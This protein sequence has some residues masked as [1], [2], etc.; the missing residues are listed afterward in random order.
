MMRQRRYSYRL[1]SCRPTQ[2]HIDFSRLATPIWGGST[3]RERSSGGC[4]PLPPSWCPV[5]PL[6]ETQSSASYSYRACGLP[7]ARLD[8]PDPPPRCNSRRGN[9]RLAA[10][11]LYLEPGRYGRRSLVAIGPSGDATSPEVI[12]SPNPTTT[13]GLSLLVGSRTLRLLRQ[14]RIYPRRVL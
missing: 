3:T 6:T 13:T 5:P 10:D 8:E 4:A 11:G 14:P 1:K 7:P 9:S 12:G 2:H